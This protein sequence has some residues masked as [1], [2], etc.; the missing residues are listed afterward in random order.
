M[1]SYFWHN[2]LED[3][4][5]T[6]VVK[7]GWYL[8]KSDNMISCP[9]IPPPPHTPYVCHFAPNNLPTPNLLCA[10]LPQPPTFILPPEPLNNYQPKPPKHNPPRPPVQTRSPTS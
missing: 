10:L 6:N 7:Q 3:D 2:G 5:W 8:V 1:L 4:T 9:L